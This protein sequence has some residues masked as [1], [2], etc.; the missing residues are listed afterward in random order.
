MSAT[1]LV[2]QS[3]KAVNTTEN[4][5][6]LIANALHDLDEHRAGIIDNPTAAARARMYTTVISALKVKIVYDKLSSKPQNIAFLA[7]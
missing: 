1:R 7:V 2:T 5:H 3:G 6:D 4:I